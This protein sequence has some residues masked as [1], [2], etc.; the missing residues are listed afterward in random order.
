MS[1]TS[2]GQIDPAQQET[3]LS[4]IVVS[5]STQWAGQPISSEERR[6]AFTAL[7]DFS[8]QFDGRVPVALE[9]LQQSQLSVANGTIDCT[10][11]AQLYACEILSACLND[12]SKKYAQWQE[13]DRLRLRQAVMVACQRQAQ[14][15]LVDPRDGSTKSSTTSTSLPLANKLASLLSALVVRDFPQRWTTCI[16]D[17]FQQLWS[18]TA[19]LVGNRMCL[20]VL[21]LVAEDCTD[22]DF[23]AKISTKR[24]NDILMGLNEVSHQFLPLLFRSL[25]HIATLTQARASIHQMRMF[26]VQNQ[27]RISTM[28]QE[29]S[30]AYWSEEAKIKGTSLVITDTLRCVNLFCR[31]MPLEWIM[32]AQ[33][34][35]S[36]A[37]FHL[38]RESTENINVLAVNCIEQLALRG[39]LSYSKWLQWIQDL[40]QAVAQ[41]NQQMAQE[42][43]FLEMKEVANTGNQSPESLDLP[44]PLTLQLDFH[45]AL[46][47]M[48]ATV[49]SSHIGLIT[50]DRSL[51]K[52][53]N[54]NKAK[55][56]K[57]T[58]TFA[59]YLRLLV[60]MLHHPSGRVV[61]EQINL[62]VGMLRDPQ[63]SKSSSILDPLV[64]DILNCFTTHM[65]KLDWEQIEDGDHPQSDLMLASWEDEDEYDHWSHEYRAKSSQLFKYVGNCQPHIASSILLARI[66]NL[67]EQHGNGEPLNHL[68]RSNQ[69][70]TNK[71]TAS[72]QFEGIIHPMENILNGLP[73][74]S[75]NVEGKS[76]SAGSAKRQQ[77]QKRLESQIRGQV[78]ASLTELSNG[79]VSWN[80]SYLWLKFRRAQMLECLKHY[81]KYHPS[82]LLQGVNSLLTYIGAPDEW[83]ETKIE[84]DGSKSIS[85]ETVGFRK[86]SSM[87][88]VGIA[89]LVPHHL[90]P[91]L[92]ELSNASRS[93]LSHPDL[94]QTNRMNLYEFLSVVASA[95]EDPMQRANFIGSVLADAVNTLQSTE[96][97]ESIASVD[98]FAAAIGIIQAGNNPASVTD[99]A[100]V[101]AVT[102][103]FSRIFSAFNELLSVGKRCHEASKKRANGGIPVAAASGA[104]NINIP[105]GMSVQ[106]AA[107]TLHFPD[108]GPV[109]IQDLARDD[110]FVPLWPRI[111]PHML[112]MLDIMFKLWHPR[113]HVEFLRNP[114]QRYALA[115]SDDDAFLSRKTDGK[116]GGVFG[117]GG[118]AGSVIPGTDRRDMNLAPRWSGWLN[119]MRNGCF[120]MLG[121]LAGQRVLYAP[122]VNEFFP[123][124]VAVVTD[125]ENLRAMEHRHCTQYLKQF[126]EILLL[127][128]PPPLYQTHVSPIVG[129][130]FEHVK[131]RLDLS[132][133]PIL[134]PSTTA[135]QPTKALFTSDCDSAAIVASQNGECWYA[136]YYARSCLFVGG[137]DTET[138]DAAVEKH[139]V[140]VTRTYSDVIQA[141]LALKG[142]WALV[143]ANLAKENE[144]QSNKKGPPT[145]RLIVADGGKVNADGTPRKANQAA[146][147][148]RKVK[149]IHALNHFMLLENEAIAGN[150]TLTVIESLAYP[151]TYTCRRITRICHRI[152][153]TVAWHPRYTDVLGRR[154]LAAITKNIV[155]QPKWM[156][157]V[158]WDVINVFRDIYCRL[159]LGQ[160]L[161]MGGQGPGLQQPPSTNRSS[162]AVYEQARSAERPLQG[163]G[164]LTTPSELPHQLLTSLQ[165]I[166]I[167]M[168]QQLDQDLRTKRSAKAQKESIREFLRVAADGWKENQHPNQ[169]FLNQAVAE[170]SLLHNANKS[171]VVED[172]PEKL[173]LSNRKSRA[174]KANEEATGLSAFSLTN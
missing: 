43:E 44:E 133:Q 30:A 37:F 7:Q 34:D 113:R 149:R 80:P 143:L 132:W 139:R 18:E 85:G 58:E 160:I 129:P 92:S 130:I 79:I 91:W 90:V 69:Q 118:T 84:A 61:G 22:S 114:V 16:Q 55:S 31:S 165:G 116:N 71:S 5:S 121:L 70:I 11:P 124:L 156:V 20:Q 53:T 82:T 155:T 88:L 87:S 100:N 40:P 170:E 42:T 151:D 104:V 3:I 32:S 148:A 60:D 4:A 10:I 115:I 36:S 174:Q 38:M 147:D 51:L 50:Q 8:T 166:S 145:S 99:I 14:A 56:N 108:E 144:S 109:S 86:K 67:I 17:L 26:L 127:S 9:W 13:G 93:L 49:V 24:R 126:I 65:V 123:Q 169:N 153:E 23:N 168:I 19:P 35:F 128:C 142:E 46:S 141:A 158:E 25:E 120:Q 96:V 68:C 107:E 89:K 146:I 150:L 59:S 66:R 64:T 103:R 74:W 72:L 21:Q 75:L 45:R 131:Y 138:A 98:N 48:L 161:Q 135:A 125:P 102:E 28:T 52:S 57:N 112:R 2:T 122:E 77:H 159:V 137:L 101:K 105:K 29:Q 157:G 171:A 140:E 167:P 117:E 134:Q 15:P 152:L 47:R 163:G 76:E 172:I 33:Y 119:E 78:L 111:L 73:A 81:W 94:L 41:A 97:Q 110:P 95:V 6:R 83:G 63:I 62:W 54:D 106:E 39:K 164:M 12:K 173:V 136:S 1:N 154:M 162:G 27:Q